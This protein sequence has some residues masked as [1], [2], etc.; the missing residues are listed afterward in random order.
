MQ[1]TLAIFSST[2]SSEYIE[3]SSLMQENLLK[4]QSRIQKIIAKKE[5]PLMLNFIHW[6]QGKRSQTSVKTESSVLSTPKTELNFYSLDNLCELNDL[7]EN[8]ASIAIQINQLVQ[9]SQCISNLVTQSQ[10][11]ASVLNCKNPTTKLSDANQA[12]Q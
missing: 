7:N 8:L 3:F 6:Q 2:L 1:A 9:Q 4:I 10:F 5:N 12:H 11:Q